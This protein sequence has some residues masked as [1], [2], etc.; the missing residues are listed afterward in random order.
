[1]S[2]TPRPTRPTIYDV[3]RE[4]GVSK[5]LV[6]L[7]LNDS[8]LVAAA[9]RTAVL[10]AID[11][12]GYRRSRAAA[13]LASKRTKTVGLIID[14]FQNPWFV[15]VLRG[16]RAA[17]GPE[18]M[19]VA[20]REQHEVGGALVNAVDGFL[21]NQ[22]DALVIAAEPGRQLPDLGIPTVVE[23]TRLHDV[24]GADHVVS[25]QELGVRL[26]MQHLHSLGHERI[27][28][29]TGQG[30][31]AAK[32]REAYLEF[33]GSIGQEPRV[34][35]QP[36][37]TNEDGGYAGTV[38]LLRRHPDVTAVFAANDTMALGARAALREVGREVP[39]DAAL[40]G[41]DNSQFARSRFLDLTTVDNRGFDVGVA[42]GELILRRL[43]DP[44]ASV[45]SV[46]I[47]SRLVVRSSSVTV[48][49]PS[50]P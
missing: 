42:C 5:S 21:D 6:S 38:E 35:G 12:L 1:M 20:I 8:D 49:R 13:N 46:V 11:K 23:G 29:V 16:L 9:K 4:A 40:I 25:D 18:G 27:G 28:H 32:R 34:A 19:H 45:Q 41:Y 3:A 33:M 31:A 37:P 17:L 50:A 43:A 36:N 7:V 22:V 30:G 47:P 26:L 48:P 39:A 2:P 24:T 15:E 10:E 44:E 14:D